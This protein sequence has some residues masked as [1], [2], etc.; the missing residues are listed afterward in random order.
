MFRTD[1]EEEGLALWRDL[2]ED[3]LSNESFL[4]E[5][6][7]STLNAYLKTGQFFPKYAEIRGPALYTAALRF[8][9]NLPR[10]EAISGS[11][12]STPAANQPK[13]QSG[14]W[15]TVKETID[16]IKSSGKL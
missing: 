16:S 9:C 3:D 1:L 13:R 2:L 10:R 5:E 12:V 7:I 15:K 6:F 4:F 11:I 8:Q 14:M